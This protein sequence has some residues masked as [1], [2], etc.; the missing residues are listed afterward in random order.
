[1]TISQPLESSPWQWPR[2]TYEVE[3]YEESGYRLH[4]DLLNISRHV[5]H[6]LGGVSYLKNKLSK[7]YLP[8]NADDFEMRMGSVWTNKLNLFCG[9]LLIS[10]HDRLSI[11]LWAYYV[12]LSSLGV[13][14][15]QSIL[16]NI[17]HYKNLQ[18]KLIALLHLI[19]LDW[20]DW[21][22]EWLHEWERSYGGVHGCGT[23]RRIS[24][25]IGIQRWRAFCFRG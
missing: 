24:G 12:F 25:R 8:C 18:Q 22:D 14:A 5:F 7:T 23:R 1:M 17:V 15:E 9:R 10:D 6:I 20:L 19:A 3:N 2:H 21:Q 4:L 11:H 16:R 13:S